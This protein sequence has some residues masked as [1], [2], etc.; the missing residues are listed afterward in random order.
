[1]GNTTADATY[2]INSL[3]VR[4][5]ARLEQLNLSFRTRIRT[6]NNGPTGYAVLN[7]GLI[8]GQ[9]NRTSV[10]ECAGNLKTDGSGITSRTNQNMGGFSWGWNNVCHSGN[11]W[12]HNHSG[13]NGMAAPG[14][15]L[16]LT[17]GTTATPATVEQVTAV[18]IDTSPFA[19]GLDA[20]PRTYVKGVYRM[21]SDLEIN[22]FESRIELGGELRANGYRLQV[23][24]PLHAGD[25]GF[26]SVSYTRTNRTQTFTALSQMVTT[27]NS[28]WSTTTS[29]NTMPKKLTNVFSGG[30]QNNQTTATGTFNF[31]G[32][33]VR[34][35]WVSINGWVGF[36]QSYSSTYPRVY[37]PHT[38]EA[39]GVATPGNYYHQINH[40]NH[41]VTWAQVPASYIA[42][43]SAQFP[44]ATTTSDR[45]VIE[46][47]TR[48]GF[49]STGVQFRY[50]MHLEEAT[51]KVF[52][53]YGSGVNQTG[54]PSLSPNWNTTNYTTMIGLEDYTGANAAVGPNN[55]TSWFGT[56]QREPNNTYEWTPQFAQNPVAKL[57]LG[58]GTGTTAQGNWPQ[59]RITGGAAVTWGDGT[60]IEIPAGSNGSAMVGASVNMYGAS[61]IQIDD[62]P[63]VPAAMQNGVAPTM[64]VVGALAV[65]GT[66]QVNIN[67]P[68]TP[69]NPTNSVLQIGQTL[70]FLDYST[71][72]PSPSSGVVNL[73]GN[74]GA[75]G[76]PTML[77]QGG[78]GG[79]LNV[80][81]NSLWR[82]TSGG[83]TAGTDTAGL[84]LTNAVFVH[85]GGLA[86]ID[87]FKVTATGNPTSLWGPHAMVIGLDQYQFQSTTVTI[88]NLKDL[89]THEI[90]DLHSANTQ[91][92][93]MHQKL[94]E[95]CTNKDARDKVGRVI[96]GIRDGIDAIES[97]CKRHGVSPTGEGCK[98]MAGLVAEA[99]AHATEADIEDSIV[100]DASIISQSSR[101]EHYALAG[102]RSCLSYARALGL[103]EDVETLHA[104]VTGTESS[105]EALRDVVIK[106]A[107][108]VKG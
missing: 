37:M 70:D 68:A 104:C 49:S 83:T 77:V 30:W 95:A 18:S 40:S 16:I 32:Q 61:R 9:L 38:N 73:N 12:P 103:D 21:E 45:I 67:V 65:G 94:A 66:A 75:T 8:H 108:T 27:P 6:Q 52:F 33:N 39:N 93:E 106:S 78:T 87:S 107:Q 89:Y 3:E 99:K 100:R 53:H 59:F 14:Y 29:Y 7:L 57:E 46:W 11:P 76:F 25:P 36:K 22:A 63:T 10:I 42:A 102:Y 71:S 80:V 60:V 51:N 81:T 69:N 48:L 84:N 50:Q 88:G 20:L 15:C 35:I 58:S 92:L 23:Q 56:S 28:L 105:G 62:Q 91:S 1:L 82:G 85:Q 19:A 101:M 74:N 4:A 43:N 17:G 24:G 2:T 26:N 86:T 64:W 44:G 98:G 72:P 47:V 55:T 96:D 54:A 41:H 34:D 97:I 5:N 13:N 79:G 31:Y 90:R